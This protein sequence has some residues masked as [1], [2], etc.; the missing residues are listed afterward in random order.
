MCEKNR[1]SSVDLEIS[2]I[3]DSNNLYIFGVSTTTKSIL[4]INIF[5]NSHW[6]LFFINN[7]RLFSNIHVEI[8][9]KLIL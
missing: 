7:G 1:M 8:K 2:Y 5:K 9:T 3:V 4:C 6:F